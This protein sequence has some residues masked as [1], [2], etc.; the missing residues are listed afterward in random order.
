MH[1]K[2]ISIHD[3]ALSKNGLYFENTGVNVNSHD[4]SGN[5][6][7]MYSIMNNSKIVLNSFLKKEQIFITIIKTMIVL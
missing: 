1:K 6:F 5:T 4:A 7:L 2:K 3:L